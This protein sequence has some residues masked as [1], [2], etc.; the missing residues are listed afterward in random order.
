MD[1]ER[2]SVSP[3]ESPFAFVSGKVV[4]LLPPSDDGLARCCVQIIY[5]AAPAVGQTA[6]LPAPPSP[7]ALKHLLKG[8]GMP[9]E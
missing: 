4:E 3:S 8:E 5:K 1:E 2:G 7:S 6:I 9:A